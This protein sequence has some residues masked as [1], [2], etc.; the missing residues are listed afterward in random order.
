MPCRVSSHRE[1]ETETVMSFNYLKLFKP[2]EH[3]E[4]NYIRKPNDENCLFQVKD[5][6]KN[7]V[8]EK[9]I[10]FQTEHKIA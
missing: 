1:I 5:N 4:E 7:Y 2:N 8:G 9:V 3:T 6:E 10:S